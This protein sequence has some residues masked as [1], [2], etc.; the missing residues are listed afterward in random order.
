MHFNEFEKQKP[1]NNTWLN[2]PLSDNSNKNECV[3][4]ISSL[5]DAMLKHFLNL[6]LFV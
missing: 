3:Q 5:V 6:K 2:N 1:F 4:F